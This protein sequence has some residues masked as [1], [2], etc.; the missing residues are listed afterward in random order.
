MDSSEKIQ[1]LNMLFQE[2]DINDEHLKLDV[3]RVAF[4]NYSMDYLLTIYKTYIGKKCPPFTT[5]DWELIKRIFDEI[6]NQIQN[7]LQSYKS[8]QNGGT[9]D[10]EP[11]PE[12]EPAP[13]P[14][15][16]YDFEGDLFSES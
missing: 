12:P 8:P 2:Y 11:E 9:D 15:L 5:E 13:E 16:E 3:L 14:G 1:Q 10:F 4:I 6:G 7:I